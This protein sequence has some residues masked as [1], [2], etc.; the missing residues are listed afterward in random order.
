MGSSALKQQEDLKRIKD[1]VFYV[2]KAHNIQ[3]NKIILFGSR[4]RGDFREGSDWDIAIILEGNV[5]KERINRFWMDVYRK[6]VDKKMYVDVLVFDKETH[7]RNKRYR[8]LINYWIER[9]GI[10]I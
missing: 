6:L 9:E 8:G 1:I 7:R 2:A 3:I 4:A 5:N 10:P